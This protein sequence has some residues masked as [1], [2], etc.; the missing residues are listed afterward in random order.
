MLLVLHVM[1]TDACITCD[2]AAGI[3]CF[4]SDIVI[5]TCHL[6]RLLLLPIYMSLIRTM[7]NV[8]YDCVV[9]LGGWFVSRK[10]WLN[11]DSAL[12]VLHSMR[13]MNLQL[14]EFLILRATFL[15]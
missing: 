8:G 2:S 6:T 5:F 14:S 10:L 12:E 3:R 4:T 1:F 15:T 9:C 11:F 7:Q 13:Y